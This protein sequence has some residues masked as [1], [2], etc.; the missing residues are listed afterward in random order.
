MKKKRKP[1]RK[2]RIK[3]VTW[4]LP[5]LAINT[6]ESA[7]IQS[8]MSPNED[9]VQIVFEDF[10]GNKF[11]IE[12][13]GLWPTSDSCTYVTARQVQDIFMYFAIE[14]NQGTEKMQEYLSKVWGRNRF[15]ARLLGWKK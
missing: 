13:K 8:H 5:K 3:E 4:Y 7:I 9:R 1:I 14:Q 12:R 11:K 6:R 10:E 2:L 15:M